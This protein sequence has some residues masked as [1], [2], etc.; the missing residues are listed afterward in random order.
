MKGLLIDA[1]EDAAK[2]ANIPTCEIDVFG[3]ECH[4]HLQN[5][6]VKAMRL[7]LSAYIK[8]QLKDSF[9]ELD[10]NSRV[11]SDCN[12]ILLL[13]DKCFNDN[14]E[15]TKGYAVEFRD[16]VERKHGGKVLFPLIRCTTGER[17]DLITTAAPSLYMN[18]PFYEEFI[19]YKSQDGTLLN[20]CEVYVTTLEFVALSRIFAIFH[21]FI[22]V[23][24]Q[25][26]AGSLHHFA[27]YNFGLAHLSKVL[28][29]LYEK[30]ELIVANSDLFLELP[31][32]KD[33]FFEV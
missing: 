9:A 8:E 14:T 29:I 27:E 4:N 32:M 19:D 5:I 17:H 18:R 11:S 13:I 2:E 10:S 7:A 16:Y 21:I 31:F 12:Q 15:Y 24:H 22:C 33:I 25:F 6:W 23:P 3:V 20:T 30:L 26:L 28:D 1:I